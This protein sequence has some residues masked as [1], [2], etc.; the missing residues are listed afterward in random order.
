M[1]A[2][3]GFIN[4]GPVSPRRAPFTVLQPP[5]MSRAVPALV[6]PSRQRS[7]VFTPFFPAPGG[8]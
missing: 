6:P 8:P 4:H 3:K 2:F 1:I 5:A 7:T